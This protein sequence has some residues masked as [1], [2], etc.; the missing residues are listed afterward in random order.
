MAITKKYRCCE[1]DDLHDT[2]DAA[3]ECCPP[4]VKP[5]WICGKCNEEHESLLLASNCCLEEDEEPQQEDARRFPSPI[6]PRDEYIKQFH[7]LNGLKV[8]GE[9]HGKT[10]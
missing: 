5:V 4:Q 10:T 7:L 8:E 6:L 1:C 3:Y 2:E 9:D